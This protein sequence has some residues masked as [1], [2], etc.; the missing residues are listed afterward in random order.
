MILENIS[1]LDK[2]TWAAD[3]VDIRYR[4]DKIKCLCNRF[5]LSQN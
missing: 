1:V 5:L 3:E 2:S 4:E